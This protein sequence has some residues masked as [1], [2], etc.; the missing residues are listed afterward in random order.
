M[1]GLY[2]FSGSFRISLNRHRSLINNVHNAELALT[3]F[4]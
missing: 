1:G 3:N 4:Q 2:L